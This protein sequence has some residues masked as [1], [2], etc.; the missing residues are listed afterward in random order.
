MISDELPVLETKITAQ[1]AQRPEYF[2][3]QPAELRVIQR[4][5]SSELNDFVRDNGWRVIRRVG[6]RQFQFYNDTYARAHA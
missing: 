3:T 5:T 1:L 2:V 4:L 6:G